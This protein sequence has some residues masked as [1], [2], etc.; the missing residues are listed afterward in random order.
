L[1]NDAA[2]ELNDSPNLGN[3]LFGLISRSDGLGNDESNLW[4]ESLGLVNRVG[5][6]RNGV[7]KPGNDAFLPICDVAG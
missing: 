7:L 2:G 3:D 5:G 4:Y 6:V 1:R